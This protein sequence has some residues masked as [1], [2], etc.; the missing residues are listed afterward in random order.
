MEE[1]LK[2]NLRKSR[3]TPQATLSEVFAQTATDAAA[4]GFVLAHLPTARAAPKTHKPILWIQDR[5]SR[6]ETGRPCLAGLGIMPQEGKT[7]LPELLWLDVSRAI[8]VL[9]AMEQGL[10]CADLGAVVGEVWGDAPQLD[11]T[12][13]KRLALRAE[14]HNVPAWLIRRAATPNLSAARERWRIASL[15]SGPDQ[16]D[17]RAPGQPVW[18]ATL[19]R[20][21]WRSPGEWVARYDSRSHAISFDPIVATNADAAMRE[22]G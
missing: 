13:S 12:A 10:A 22:V 19:M 4:I 8:D 18:K 17:M 11:F 6:R 7:A 3:R 2:T 16:A 9:W 14:A 20:A 15:P 5:L 1:N 21:R